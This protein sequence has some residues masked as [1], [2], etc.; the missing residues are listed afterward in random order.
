MQRSGTLARRALAGRRDRQYECATCG[1][2]FDADRTD[3][4]ACGGRVTR[5]TNDAEGKP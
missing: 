1:L 3:C 4:P 2:T 5:W